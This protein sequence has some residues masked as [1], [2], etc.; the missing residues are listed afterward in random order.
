MTA[1]AVLDLADLEPV[2]PIQVVR[3]HEQTRYE[4]HYTD[5]LDGGCLRIEQYPSESS[6]REA[7]AHLHKAYGNVNVFIV[8][9]QWN[10]RLTEPN[11]AWDKILNNRTLDDETV[12]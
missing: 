7:M 3:V 2:Q 9:Q 5:P 4:L 6:A 1:V 12:T 11:N 10:E 8:W